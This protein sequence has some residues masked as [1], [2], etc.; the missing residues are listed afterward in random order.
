MS[1]GGPAA[2]AVSLRADAVLFDIDDTLVDFAGAARLALLGAIGSATGLTPDAILASWDRLSQVQ[3]DRYTA[4]ELDFDGMRVARMKVVLADLDPAGEYDPDVIEA[5]RHDAIFG[6]YRLFDDVLPCLSRLRAAGVPVGLIS[7][8]DGDYQRRKLAAV[9]LSDLAADAVCSGDIGVA[10]PDPAIFAVACEQLGVHPGRAVY[11]GDRWTTD[12]LGS[13]AAGMG[14]VWL[15]RNHLPRP[16]PT[17]TLLPGRQFAEL[18]T[19]TPL[20]LTHP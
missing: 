19:L 8:S 17:P 2:N 6:H 7:N 16:A 1:A 3:Y 15:N 10:K 9:G 5:A 20:T 4:G 18:P 14:A 13:L 12:V 11:V